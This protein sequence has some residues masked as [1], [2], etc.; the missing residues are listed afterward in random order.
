[1][2]ELSVVVPCVS[3]AEMLPGF[4]DKL[5]VYLMSNPGEIDVIVVAN[6]GVESAQKLAHYVQ[7][8]YPWLR[9]EM[10]R[11]KGAVRNYGAL[12]RFGIAYSTSH[13]VVLV[14]PYGEDDVSIIK[15]MLKKMREGRQMVQAITR[16]SRAETE[17]KQI[18][19][20][21]YRSVFRFMARL[22]VGVRI[23]SAT[24]TFKM[25]DRVFVQ[26]VGLTQNGHTICPEITL[27]VL[28]AGGGVDYI[29]S[30]LDSQ[31]VNK[32]FKVYK[33]GIHYFWLLLRGLMHRTG[34]L[35][36]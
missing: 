15:P 32:D 23:Q 24:N 33:E 36:F 16:F 29:Y 8:K 21:I 22:M 17:P 4:I 7:E 34:I 28:L 27:K 14:S 35:W 30:N 25:F 12:A 31:P 1:M 9:F 5:A 20:N 18:I 19:F 26:A 2:N 11:R 10:L 6:E 13:Y 3:T